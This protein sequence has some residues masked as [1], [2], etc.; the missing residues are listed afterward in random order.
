MPATDRDGAETV[1]STPN[2]RSPR[3]VARCR[4]V[5]DVIAADACPGRDGMRVDSR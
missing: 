5:G 3:F 4:R 1:R 2:R